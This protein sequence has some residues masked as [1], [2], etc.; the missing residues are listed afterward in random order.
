MVEIPDEESEKTCYDEYRLTGASR[1]S[2]KSGLEYGP[3]K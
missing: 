3:S 2:I 1:S